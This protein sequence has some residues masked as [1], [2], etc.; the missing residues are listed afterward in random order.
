VTIHQDALLFAGLFDGAEQA[1]YTLP[2]GRIGYVHVVRGDVVVNA[3][4]LSA[5]DA[6]KSRGGEL[7]IERGNSA[8]VLVFDLPGTMQS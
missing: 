7:L 1:R 3:H 6:L 2:V 8:E 4:A 5:G